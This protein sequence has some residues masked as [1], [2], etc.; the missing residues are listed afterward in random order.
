MH[1]TICD[2]CYTE[3]IVNVVECFLYLGEA[4]QAEGLL[5]RSLQ[6]SSVE[7]SSRSYYEP[8]F[9]HSISFDNTYS[10]VEIQRRLLW[11]T[12]LVA[13]LT[14]DTNRLLQS[15]NDMNTH[16]YEFFQLG[17]IFALLQSGRPLAALKNISSKT[18]GQVA[19]LGE[20]V[21]A[22]I[23]V[24]YAL[25]EAECKLE[26]ELHGR[27]GV[28]RMP[29]LCKRAMHMSQSHLV[30]D[31]APCTASTELQVILY[32]NMAVSYIIEG[33]TE[34]AME[35][36]EKACQLSERMHFQ[37]NGKFCLSLLQPHFNL[38]LHHIQ[39]NNLN[40]ALKAW[41]V[42][43]H[44]RFSS[45]SSLLELKT[46]LDKSIQYHFESISH[47]ESLSASLHTTSWKP[48][49]FDKRQVF[50]MDCITLLAAIEI[51]QTD[52]IT[53]WGANLQEEK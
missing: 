16:D 14:Q 32:N 23:A 25:Y 48:G 51:R 20:R 8:S 53:R 13:S 49:L 29:Y 30:A 36:F 41:R 52:C 4:R 34:A 27:D 37:E 28:L 2:D 1:S 21:N 5:L 39:A 19:N 10:S 7:D 40:G 46:M 18:A 35:C 47:T 43:R 3:T 44:Y 15:A 24:L 33:K 45:A 12:F 17:N 6:L 11:L 9:R 31:T 26:L 22:P 50:L 38:A 42:A